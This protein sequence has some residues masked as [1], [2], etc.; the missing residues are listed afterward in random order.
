MSRGHHILESRTT[1][2]TSRATKADQASWSWSS[3]IRLAKAYAYYLGANTIHHELRN[4]FGKSNRSKSPGAGTGAPGSN[5]LIT[6]TTNRKLPGASPG[7]PGSNF[8]ICLNRKLIGN[9]QEQAPGLLGVIALFFLIGL[10]SNSQE[11][12]LGLPRAIS[13]LC[14]IENSKGNC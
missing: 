5:V 1:E 3:C 10:I 7:A 14:A 4:T 13:L 12:A 2:N 8:L 9:D 6:V 11:Q